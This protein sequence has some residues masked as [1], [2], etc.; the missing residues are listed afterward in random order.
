MEIGIATRQQLERLGWKRGDIERALAAGRVTRIRPG[1]F[2]RPDAPADLVA[3]VRCGGVATGP[4]ALRHHGLWAPEDRRLHV[5]VAPNASRLAAA[6]DDVVLHWSSSFADVVGTGLRFRPIAPVPAA[7]EHAITGVN[8]PVAIAVIDSALHERRLSPAALDAVLSALPRRLRRRLERGI[9]GRA[10]SGIESMCRVL[11]EDAGLRPEVQVAIPGIG[12]VDL[13]IDGWLIVELDGGQHADAA[14]M[15]RDRAR[16]AAAIRLGYRTIR[17]SY[18][19]VVHEWP[20]SLATI[21]VALASGAPV[22]LAI[23]PAPG[24]RADAP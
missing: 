23:R 7:V 3:A 22:L 14:Q 20:R 16:D 17:L 5:A 4:T 15:R 9:D 11:L 12:R 18:P 21:R 10:E 24:W 1:Y 19:D 8:Q 13:L 2:A 6:G